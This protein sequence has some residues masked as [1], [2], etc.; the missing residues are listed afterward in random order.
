MRR[1]ALIATTFVGLAAGAT[2][3]HAQAWVPDKGDLGL[4]LDYN[5]STSSKVVTNTTYNFDD[6]GTQGH[7]ITVGAEYVPIEKLSIG[8][9]LPFLAIKYTGDQSFNHGEYDDGDF[10]TTLTDLRV[11]A[12]YQVLDDPLALTPH[13]A[14]TI[15]VADYATEGNTVAGRHLKQL[16]AGVSVGYL[17]GLASYVHAMYEFTLSEK[18]DHNAATKKF[19]QNYSD[20]SAAFGHKVLDYK[21][22]LHLAAAYRFHHG[23]INLLD[24]DSNPMYEEGKYANDPLIA[25]FHDAILKESAFLVGGGVGYDLSSKLTATLDFRYFVEPL[26]KNT[27]NASIV[28]LSLQWA[29]LAP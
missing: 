12:R 10:H 23:G 27:V 15:P 7:E 13:L 4:E 21:M 17:V 26:S 5:F 25:P 11:G 18:D 6:A 2:H 3:A 20:F 1:L 16:H 28:A 22:D 8:A 14:V 19:T 29:P 24:I 9:S